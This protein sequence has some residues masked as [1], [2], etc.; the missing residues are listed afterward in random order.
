[1][2]EAGNASYR[3]LWFDTRADRTPHGCPLRVAGSSFRHGLAVHSKSVVKIPLKKGFARFEAR[4]GID[5]ETLAAAEN[6]RGDV[7]ARVT[8]D[9]RE[10][11]TS[12]ASHVKSGEAARIVGPIDVTGVEMLA[13]EVEF[14]DGMEVNDRADWGDPVLVR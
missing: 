14:G 1:M 13:L 12:G 8:T 7:T 4:F 10:V 3:T 2:D 6:V 9:G 11:W 5:D